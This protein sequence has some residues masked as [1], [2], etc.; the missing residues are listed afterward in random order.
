MWWERSLVAKYYND[1]GDNKR[2]TLLTRSMSGNVKL[3]ISPKQKGRVVDELHLDVVRVVETT[4]IHLIHSM[5]FQGG[6]RGHSPSRTSGS[7]SD[8]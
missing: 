8:I 7:V 1:S 6:L 2:W 4:F 3:C 5:G